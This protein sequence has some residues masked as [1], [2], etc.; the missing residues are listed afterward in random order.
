[1]V[2][3]LLKTFTSKV[4]GFTSVHFYL[5]VIT[6]DEKVG[7]KQEKFSSEGTTS[8]ERLPDTEIFW[9]ISHLWTSGIFCLS[10]MQSLFGLHYC[11]SKKMTSLN[12]LTNP[13]SCLWTLFGLAPSSLKWRHLWMTPKVTKKSKNRGGFDQPRLANKAKE[14]VVVGDCLT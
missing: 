3:T 4:D 11:V 8:W 6:S 5:K 1:M 12:G 7:Y 10:A 13:S 2:Y 9:P 14:L